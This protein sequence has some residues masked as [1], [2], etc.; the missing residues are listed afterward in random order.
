M[1]RTS[2]YSCRRA[3]LPVAAASAP[4]SGDG[5][6]TTAARVRPSFTPGVY[7]LAFRDSGVV[8]KVRWCARARVCSHARVCA[9]ERV[10]MCVG[11]YMI[12]SVRGAR[13]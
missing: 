10:F 2:D 3:A 1:W 12:V 4:A 8:S 9:R 7:E 6:P 13:R 5:A 11:A